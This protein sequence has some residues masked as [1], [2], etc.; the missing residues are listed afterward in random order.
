MRRSFLDTPEGQVHYATEG[1]GEPVLLLHQ[2]PNSID[3]YRELIPLLAKTRRVIAIDTIGYGD[4]YKPAREVQIEDFAR[5]AVRVLDILNIEET[6]LVGAHT[7]SLVSI[8][9]AA[10]YP[11]RV[12][13]MVLYSPP[14]IDEE[15]RRAFRGV[16]GERYVNDVYDWKVEEDGSHLQRLWD[17]FQSGLWAGAPPS[18]A[19]RMVIDVLKSG[20]GFV[21]TG[22]NA[23]LRY[24]NM[25]DRLRLVQCPTLVVWGTANLPQ[26]APENK[27]MAGK[28]IPRSKGV[29]IEGGDAVVMTLMADEYAQLV[30]EFLANPGI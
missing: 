3:Q 6:S 11:E 20:V 7:G 23:V 9:L 16:M 27:A 29:E 24:T 18:L 22:L 2:T 26:L 28:L 25:G 21:D 4:S 5:N 13:A 30:L 15:V 19:N 10:A 8:E 1:S 17:S 14:Y 12:S